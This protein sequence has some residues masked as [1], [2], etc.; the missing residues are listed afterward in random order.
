MKTF[1]ITDIGTWIQDNKDQVYRILTYRKV[2][3]PYEIDKKYSDESIFEEGEYYLFAR[4]TNAI[5]VPEGTLLELT[6]VVQGDDGIWIDNHFT[7][8]KL[9]SSIKL[10]K[11]GFDNVFK[12]E[13]D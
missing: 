8:Y 11:T 5:E 10:E 2:W 6:E 7:H 12:E 9:L 13:E 4:I 1:G 3:T